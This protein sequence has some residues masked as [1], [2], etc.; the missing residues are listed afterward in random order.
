M[1]NELLEEQATNAMA[2]LI[3][4][5]VAVKDF[6]IEQAPDVIDQLLAWNY[7]VSLMACV[8]VA[9]CVPVSIF[10][11][12]KAAKEWELVEGPYNDGKAFVWSF[13][14]GVFGVA[15][16]VAT[17]CVISE[18]LDWLQITIAPKLYLIEYAASLAK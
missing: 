16:L 17:P 10:I 13:I 7:T 12:A 8:A 14:A 6:T 1:M 9:C 11:A 18:N 15:T 5:F 2:G 3:E 4:S